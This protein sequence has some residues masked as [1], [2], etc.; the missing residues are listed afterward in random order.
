MEDDMKTEKRR[1]DRWQKRCLGLC[2]GLRSDDPTQ[3]VSG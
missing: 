1:D 2:H 3:A